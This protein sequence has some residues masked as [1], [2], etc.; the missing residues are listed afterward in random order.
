MHPLT[1]LLSYLSGAWG[2][3]VYRLFEFEVDARHTPRGIPVSSAASP[4]PLFGAN[5]VIGKSGLVGAGVGL[6]LGLWN[7]LGGD[8]EALVNVSL[9]SYEIY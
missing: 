4:R 3:L 2:R 1:T 6:V 8:L 7:V 9:P 5:G